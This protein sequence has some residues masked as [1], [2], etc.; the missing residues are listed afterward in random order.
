MSERCTEHAW[1]SIG[2][3]VVEGTVTR[4]WACEHCPAWTREGLMPEEEVD[5]DDTWLSRM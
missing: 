5:W 4:V 1:A 2:V 3:T